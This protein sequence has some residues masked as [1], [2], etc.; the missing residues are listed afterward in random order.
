MEA[1]ALEFLKTTIE[2]AT[3]GERIVTTDREPRHVYYVLQPDGKLERVESTGAPDAHQAADLDTLVRAALETHDK[4]RRAPVIWYGRTQVVAVMQPGEVASDVCRVALT[5]SPQLARLADWDRA[6][7]ASP[8]QAEL[9]VL[10]RT[11]F[12][13]CVPD[14]FLPAVRGVK[15][16]KKMDADSQISHGRVSLGKS[17]IAEM[18]GVAA[19]PE[20]VSFMVPVFAQAAV[21]IHA[22]IRVEVEPDAQNERFN[23]YVIP[24]DIE[25]AFA[26]AEEVIAERLTRLLGES[27][28]PVYRGTP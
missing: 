2:A 23:L 15:S 27:P 3:P 4:D 28:I 8:S 5:P 10:L 21:E 16:T 25:H 13:G 24:G 7:K 12:T 20:R 14:D 22:T 1:K 9:V 19:I 11:L 6:G 17:M 26:H 18:S